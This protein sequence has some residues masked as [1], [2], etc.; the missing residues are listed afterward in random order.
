MRAM[1]ESSKPNIPRR[2]LNLGKLRPWVQTAFL[3]VWLD[4]LL[5][6]WH[7]VPGC[8]FHCYA[9][10]LATVAC[11]IG[12]MSQFAAMH[13]WPLMILGVLITV[14]GLFGTAVCG[15][16]CPFGFFQD[17]LAKIP[18]PKYSLPSWLGYGRFVTLIGLVLLIPFFF[19]DDHPLFFCNVCPAGAL[20]AALGQSIYRGQLFIP[21]T[22]KLIVTGVVLFLAFF[23]YR[24]WCRIFCPLGGIFAIFNRFSLLYL[25]YNAPKCTECNLCRSRCKYDVKLDKSINNASCIRCMECTNCP[26]ITLTIAGKTPQTPDTTPPQPAPGK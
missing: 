15:W 16:A 12:L 4:P 3:A 5:L 1:A 2:R 10:P 23:T 19:G 18:T 8:V 17:L 25:H 26:A 14:G 24:P 21:N 9:C 6:R 22:I 20:E 7:S 11:P 13:M